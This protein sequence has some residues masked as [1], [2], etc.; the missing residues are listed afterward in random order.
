MLPDSKEAVNKR[1]RE[2][3]FNA[4]VICSTLKSNSLD[5]LA[6]MLLRSQQGADKSRCLGF[7]CCIIDEASQCY[8]V[9]SLIPLSYNVNKLF[10]V[11]D[12]KGLPPVVHSQVIL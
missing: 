8:E 7:T 10:L 6:E 12:K 4:N 2:I 11:G 5:V 3:I 9:D 1:R